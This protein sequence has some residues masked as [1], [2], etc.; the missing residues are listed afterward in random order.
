M[1]LIRMAP[2]TFEGL[3]FVE[4]IKPI[5]DICVLLV[6]LLLTLCQCRVS[7]LVAVLFCRV[8]RTEQVSPQGQYL[9]KSIFVVI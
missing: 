5:L 2:W 1:T 4:H 3:L 9:H 6:V 7:N 8:S